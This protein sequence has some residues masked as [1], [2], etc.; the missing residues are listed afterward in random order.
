MLSLPGVQQPLEPML[1]IVVSALFF[2]ISHTPY[3][4]PQIFTVQILALEAVLSGASKYSHIL[5]HCQL[6]SESILTS[7]VKSIVSAK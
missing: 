6:S 2:Q 3:T 4:P 5:A 1:L 7:L